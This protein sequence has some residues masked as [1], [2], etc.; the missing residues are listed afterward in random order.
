M[1]WV[2]EAIMF[3]ILKKQRWKKA[4]YSIKFAWNYEMSHVIQFYQIHTYWPLCWH[5]AC[6]LE[7]CY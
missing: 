4:L 6:A 7:S 2:K 5:M 3:N 1:V